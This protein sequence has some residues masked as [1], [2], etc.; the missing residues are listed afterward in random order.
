MC[1]SKLFISITHRSIVVVLLVLVVPLVLVV[2]LSLIVALVILI[3]LLLLASCWLLIKLVGI[4]FTPLLLLD[5]L[6]KVIG[7]DSCSSFLNK[8]SAT[9]HHLLVE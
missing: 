1:G 7:Y 6:V 3:V 8:V 9:L 2:L 4:T 5:R